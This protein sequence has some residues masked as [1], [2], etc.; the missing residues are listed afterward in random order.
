MLEI[1]RELVDAVHSLKGMSDNRRAELHAQ[2]D[3]AGKATEPEP[4]P[5]PGTKPK[6]APAKSDAPSGA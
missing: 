1:V 5:E 4:E 2:L 6:P 3:D